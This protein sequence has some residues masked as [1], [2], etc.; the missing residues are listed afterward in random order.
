MGEV[1]RARDCLVDHDRANWQNQAQF[2]AIAAQ[3]T[4]ASNSNVHGAVAQANG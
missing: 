4:L 1:Y 2:L 3:I